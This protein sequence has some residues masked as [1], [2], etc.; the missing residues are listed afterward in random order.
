MRFFYTTATLLLLTAAAGQAGTL[1][2]SYDLGSGRGILAGTMSGALQGDNNTFV[3]SSLD[4]Y[5]YN[6]AA[7]P[8]LTFLT[9]PDSLLFQSV[10]NPKVTLNGSFMDFVAC[11]N[12]NCNSE[13]FGWVV[14]DSFSA[15]LYAG[16]P[17][18]LVSHAF[19]G[20][21][22]PYS[23]SNWSAS[24]G[25]DAPEPGTLTLGLAAAGFAAA[26]SRRKR[27]VRPE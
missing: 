14:G 10:L 7:G 13:Y 23:A 24:V 16:N 17:Y 15:A 12:T 19:G 4:S 1:N 21:N 6:G 26:L 9:T 25:G 20:N 27:L 22:V 8:S 2:F 5:T 3:V 18:A 11:S